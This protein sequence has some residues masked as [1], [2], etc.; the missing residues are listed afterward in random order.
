MKWFKNL[1]VGTK[2][3]FAFCMASSITLIVGTTG[4]VGVSRLG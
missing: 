3:L 2:L 4:F 1:K